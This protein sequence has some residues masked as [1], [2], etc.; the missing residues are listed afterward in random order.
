MGKEL[1]T[2]FANDVFDKADTEDRSGFADKVHLADSLSFVFGMSFT[3][4][5]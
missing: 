5:F 1:V 2:Q 3:V 4:I